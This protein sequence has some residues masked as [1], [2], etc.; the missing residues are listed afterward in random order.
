MRPHL[1]LSLFEQLF[2]GAGLLP[3]GPPAAAVTSV[4]SL[5]PAG[6][7]PA[8]QV[9]RYVPTLCGVPADDAAL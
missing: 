6:Q 8:G 9:D 5:Q 3:C 1:L 4:P 2:E 7:E